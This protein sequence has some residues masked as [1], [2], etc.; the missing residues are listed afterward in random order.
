M[1]QL[2]LK[3][4]MW[5][6]ALFLNT[7]LKALKFSIKIK[8][9]ILNK[10][11][12]TDDEVGVLLLKKE[13]QD[14]SPVLGLSDLNDHVPTKLE[15]LKKIQDYQLQRTKALVDRGYIG[16]IKP[17]TN[18]EEDFLYANEDTDVKLLSEMQKEKKYHDKIKAIRNHWSTITNKQDYEIWEKEHQALVADLE[19]F[20][21]E[22]GLSNDVTEIGSDSVDAIRKATS[23]IEKALNIKE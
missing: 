1:K 10:R 22:I 9:A 19:N 17:T 13:L 12:L 21:K 5:F 7:S 8:T 18:V 23:D 15:L 3:M 14:V 16:C 11:I 6:I 4:S 20:K 2:L